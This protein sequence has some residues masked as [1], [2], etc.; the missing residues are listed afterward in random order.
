MLFCSMSM[1]TICNSRQDMVQPAQECTQLL[2]LKRLS[3]LIFEWIR[4]RAAALEQRSSLLARGLQIVL[5][6]IVGCAFSR[7]SC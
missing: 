5:I 3:R 7:G 1:V 6:N 2:A 4:R